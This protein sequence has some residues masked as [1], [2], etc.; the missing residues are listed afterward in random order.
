[1]L[2]TLSFDILQLVAT[3]VGAGFP[4]MQTCAALRRRLRVAAAPAL[5]KW[6][7]PLLMEKPTVFARPGM[8]P[9]GAALVVGLSPLSLMESLNAVMGL[10]QAGN[11]EV[12]KWFVENV[13]EWVVMLKGLDFRKHV[14]L[15]TACSNGHVM[16]ARWIDSVFGTI[17]FGDDILGAACKGGHLRAVQWVLVRYKFTAEYILRYH[18]DDCAP[19]ILEWA[20][21]GNANRDSP[22][23]PSPGS[24][25]GS[26]PGPSLGPRPAADAW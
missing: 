5:W 25:P 18:I 9:A 7:R 13:P 1:M 11:V 24:L 21:A 17:R 16:M 14:M 3:F 23:G 19:N 8:T 4:T 26:S 12:A 2:I 10:C 6:A 15:C 22:L 20:I